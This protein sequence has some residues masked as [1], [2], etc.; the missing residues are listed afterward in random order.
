MNWLDLLVH[1]L[2]IFGAAYIVG[3]SQISLV[4]RVLLANT[5]VGRFFVDLLECPACF[6]THAAWVLTLFDRSLFERTFW[7]TAAACCFY[8]CTSYLLARVTGL[9][10]RPHRYFTGPNETHITEA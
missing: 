3:H 6:S 10:D 4:P 2:A 9:T 8:A 1:V 7:G 5:K